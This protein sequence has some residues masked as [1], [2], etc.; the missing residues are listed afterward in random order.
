MFGN[1]QKSD[2]HKSVFPY[3]FYDDWHAVAAN[4]DK[5][6]NLDMS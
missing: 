3:V 4:R 5:L 6:K 2:D 1:N